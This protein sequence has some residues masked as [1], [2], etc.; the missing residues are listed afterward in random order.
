VDVLGIITSLQHRINS[1][2][3]IAKR[4]KHKHLALKATGLWITSY[5]EV[6]CMN[7]CKISSTTLVMA[8]GRVWKSGEIIGDDNQEEEAESLG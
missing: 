2:D 7:V 6:D 4:Q 1:T 8:V 3:N 5:A